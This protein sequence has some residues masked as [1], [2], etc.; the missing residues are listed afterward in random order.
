MEL[1]KHRWGALPLYIGNVIPPS[2][3]GGVFYEAITVSLMMYLLTITLGGNHYIAT[4]DD[5]L[6][7]N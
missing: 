6:Y 5:L 2:T 1:L 3:C 7:G 4:V